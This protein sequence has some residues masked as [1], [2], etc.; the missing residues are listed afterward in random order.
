MSESV[1]LRL[2]PLNRKLKAAA[3]QPLQHA[4]F[5]QGVEF[6]C[7]GRGLCNGCRVRVV[8]G[9]LPVTSEDE[10]KLSPQQLAQGWRLAC[11]ARPESDLTL[12]VAQWEASILSDSTPFTFSPREGLGV[13]IDLGTTTVVAQ[14][15]DFQNGNVLGVRTGLNIQAQHGADIMSRIEYAVSG[16]GQSR[17]ESLIREQIFGMIRELIADIDAGR[18]Q[19]T[20]IV[21]AGNTAMHHLFCGLSAKPLSTYPFEPISPGPQAFAAKELGW[22]LPGHPVVEFLACLGGFVGSD[23]LAGIVAT[24]MADRTE[25][26]VLLDLGT[27]GEIVV[28]NA[29]RFL[30]T[31][32]AAGPAFE[33][34]MIS[35][36]MRAATGAI[37]EVRAQ[38]GGLECVVL[39]GGAPRGVCGSGLVDA[40]AA[41]LDLGWILPRGKLMLGEIMPLAGGV[42]LT[43]H[44]IRQLQLAK[45]AI[46]AGVFVLLERWGAKAADVKT[47]FL[48]GAFG[49]YVNQS[50]ARRIGLL[51][52]SADRVKPSGNTALLGAK[53]ALFENGAQ[54][55]N[56]GVLERCSHVPLKE[57]AGFQDAYVDAMFFP[58]AREP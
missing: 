39:G 50:S 40:V 46:A 16:G 31:S 58:N 49:N 45:A 43:Q 7:G 12:E 57:D 34:A 38:Q 48:A 29:D 54:G 25:L 19:V 27:N 32:T 11:R 18:Q 17:L 21:L 37:S 53:M 42:H 28:G 33:G 10:R 26:S 20:R 52:F 51:N 15:V 23:I 22:D 24:G 55:S 41:G 6:P 3:G 44:D 5:A 8:A 1:T 14:L 30:C 36:G 4:L 2:V 56:T 47:V 35:M 13:A 9:S